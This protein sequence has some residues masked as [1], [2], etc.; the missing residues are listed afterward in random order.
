MQAQD[1]FG[2][3]ALDLADDWDPMQ[4]NPSMSEDAAPNAEHKSPAGYDKSPQQTADPDGHRGFTESTGAG[5]QPTSARRA[6]YNTEVRGDFYGISNDAR[7]LREQAGQ[8]EQCKL[9]ARMCMHVT[10]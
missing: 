7:G 8:K 10:V 5:R 6:D 2:L 9:N 1:D 4:Q 3:A